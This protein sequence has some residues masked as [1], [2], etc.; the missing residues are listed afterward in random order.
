MAASSWC[1]ALRSTRILQ[2]PHM[3]R[4]PEGGLCRSCMPVAA[5]SPQRSVDRGYIAAI[6]ASP[7]SEHFTSV[8]PSIRRAKS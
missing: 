5:T 3:H 1:L 7:N 6:S 4:P 8:E 2:T